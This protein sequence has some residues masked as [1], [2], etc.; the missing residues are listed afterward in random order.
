MRN[1]DKKPCSI[2]GELFSV[3][4]MRR[5]FLSK[6]TENDKKPYKC[7]VCGKGFIG[8]EVLTLH[9]NTHTGNKPFTC[10]ICGKGFADRN[11]LRV[12]IRAHKGIKRQKK[13]KVVNSE[14]TILI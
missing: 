1:H 2:C 3:K 14:G 4:Q 13:V 8:K 7:E 12:H 5:H 6:H 10:D 9:M 11:N